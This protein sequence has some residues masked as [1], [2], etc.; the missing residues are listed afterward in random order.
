MSFFALTSL[1]GSYIAVIFALLLSAPVDLYAGPDLSLQSSTPSRSLPKARSDFPIPQD[2]DQVFYVQRSMNSNT[3]VYKVNFASDGT[4]SSNRPMSAYW[5]RFNTTGA[6]KSLSFLEKSFAYGVSTHPN[7]DGKTHSVKFAALPKLS[8]TL[9]QSDKHKA[10]LWANINN[11]EY[12]MISAFLDLDESG[13]FPKV[14]R[15]RLYTSE[16]NTGLFVTHLV[17]VSGGDIR[18]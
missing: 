14:V 17:S 9:R 7:V 6:V 18:K 10:A 8:V 3:V 4:L 2:S 15:L 12:R 5:R 16:P 13:L 1:R 11:Q